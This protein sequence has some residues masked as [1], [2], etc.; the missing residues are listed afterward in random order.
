MDPYVR[1]R[2]GHCVY[3]THTDPSGGKNPKWNKEVFC[4]LPQGVTSIYLELYDEC[5][6]TM[7][8]LIAWAKIPIPASVMKGETHEDWFSLSGKQGEDKEGMINLV[9]SYTNAPMPM[10]QYMMPPVAPVMMVPRTG[11]SMFGPAYAPAQVYVQ[12]PPV[13]P[14]LAAPQPPVQLS[15]TDLKQIQEM[16]PNMDE[17]VVKS[18]FEVNRGSKDATVNSLLQMS[19]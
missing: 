17:D 18:V 3:E 8:E 11:G 4:L 7:D 19:E 13:N 10:G 12:Q 2:V 14:A 9:L 1:L 16:F 15:E 5:S 6:F